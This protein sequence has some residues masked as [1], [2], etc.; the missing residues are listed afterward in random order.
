MNDLLDLAK[1]D[2]GKLAIEHNAFDLAALL[3]G[4]V[5]GH[6]H[7]AAARGLGLT[8]HIQPGTARRVKGDAPR[9]RQML[10]NLLSN[11]VKFTERGSVTV[12]VSSGV[13]ASGHAQVRIDVR[14]TGAGIAA[15]KL[16]L[17]FE[18]FTQSDGSVSRKHGGTGLGLSLTRKL[19]ELHGGSCNSSARRRLGW[20]PRRRPPLEPCGRGC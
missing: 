4:S 3:E 12:T 15:E 18:S 19:A 10:E 9:I 17:I 8:L 6:S 5:N 1:I 20:T 11:A 13:L 16:P 14:D 7:K 2:S